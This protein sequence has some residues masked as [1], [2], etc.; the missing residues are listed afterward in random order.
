MSQAVPVLFVLP[1]KSCIHFTARNMKHQAVYS[2]PTGKIRSRTKLVSSPC[3][4]ML[5]W[6]RRCRAQWETTT[7]LPLAQG[8]VKPAQLSYFGFFC[9]AQETPWHSSQLRDHSCHWVIALASYGSISQLVAEQHHS[10]R[11][12]FWNRDALQLLC[13]WRAHESLLT[14]RQQGRVWQVK[15][16]RKSEGTFLSLPKQMKDQLSVQT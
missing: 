7:L 16:R 13:S 6:V 12:H 8:Q 4:V 3:S 1:E 10:C 11:H 2:H 15:A 9:I 5:E 14:K